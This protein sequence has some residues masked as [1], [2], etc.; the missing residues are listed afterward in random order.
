MMTCRELIDFLMDYANGDL[1]EPARVEF[2]RHLSMCPSCAVYLDTYKRTIEL[3]RSAC[4]D[5]DAPAADKVPEDLIRAI[6]AARAKA[7]DARD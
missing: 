2:E 3:A 6:L 4:N 5:P 1:P 7:S